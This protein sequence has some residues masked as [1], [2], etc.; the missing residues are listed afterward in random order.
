M[1]ISTTLFPRFIAHNEVN[2]VL[3]VKMCFAQ[4]CNGRDVYCNALSEVRNEWF[5]TDQF[6]F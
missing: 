5:Q 2:A 6:K 1:S 3:V 4:D